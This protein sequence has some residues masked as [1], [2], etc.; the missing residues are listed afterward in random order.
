[1]ILQIAI[2]LVLVVANGFFVA[3]EFAVARMR[4][5]QLAAFESAGRPGAKSLRHAVEHIDAYL[6]ACQLGITIS[7][8]GLGFV[9]KPAFEELLDP[10]SE[11]LG[12]ATGVAAYALSYFFA[13]ALVTFLHV[14]FGELAP[15][16]MAISRNTATALA[17]AFPMRVFY[18]AM[19]PLVDGFNWMGNLVLRPFGIP[20]AREAGH[21]PHSEDELREL[22]RH[23]VQEG[24]LEPSDLQYTERVFAFADRRAR[25]IMVP[26]PEID[27]VTTEQTLREAADCATRTGHTR[28][29]LCE[30]D[31]GLDVPLGVVNAKDVL[32][33]V[34]AGDDPPLVELARPLERVSESMRIDELLTQL[35]AERRHV[36]LVVDEHGTTVG[37]VSLEDVLEELVGEIEDEF[38]PRTEELF[39]E[40]DG[41]LFVRGSAPLHLVAERVGLELDGA[42]ESTIGGHVLE[43][44]GRLPEAAESVAID[45]RT[46]EIVAV[47]DGRIVELRFALEHRDDA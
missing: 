40:R 8:I 9:G 20:P 47:A 37:L 4:P 21:V 22:L 18:Y 13:F 45:G 35:R 19:K 16:S 3:T 6:A 7:S 15:K 42:H 38:D 33:S 31:G 17:V 41:A 12:D 2:A 29:P 23:S 10:V 30:P 32:R 26:R 11:Q 27:F 43:Q 5:T 39:L 36:A 25:Q 34:L 44:L 14:V 46:A 28:L 1:M 24:L